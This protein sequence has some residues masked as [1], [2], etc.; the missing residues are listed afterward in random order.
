MFGGLGFFSYLRR[1]NDE[2]TE[3]KHPLGTDMCGVGRVVCAEHHGEIDNEQATT[4]HTNQ[5][6]R[7]HAVD[8]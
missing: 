2:N 7:H 8:Y 5:S 1:Q 6:R 4:H 3:D